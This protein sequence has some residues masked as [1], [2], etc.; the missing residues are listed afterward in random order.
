MTNIEA[1]ERQTPATS[2]PSPSRKRRWTAA[3]IGLLLTGVVMILAG[4]GMLAGAGV[5]NAVDNHWRDGKY[6]TS[7]TTQLSTTGHALAV[8]EIDLDG[9][10]GD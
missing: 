8:E 6:L 10:G 4:L 7:D 9:L 5:L 2:R 1:P 3:N